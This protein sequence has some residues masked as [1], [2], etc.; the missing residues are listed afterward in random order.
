MNAPGAEVR[1][2]M[3]GRQLFV[4]FKGFGRHLRRCPGFPT[5]EKFGE[6]ELAGIL[7]ADV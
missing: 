5:I 1:P 7:F 2:D 4:A 6:G 3:V